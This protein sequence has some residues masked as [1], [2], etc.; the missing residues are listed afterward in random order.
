MQQWPRLSPLL[1]EGRDPLPRVKG[2]KPAS[3]DM[4]M[5]LVGMADSCRQLCRPARLAAIVAR[6]RCCVLSC[7]LQIIEL[8]PGPLWSSRSCI[9][10]SYGLDSD[11]LHGCD[12]AATMALCKWVKPRHR[13][14]LST[15]TAY[16]A[17]AYVAM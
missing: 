17:M 11:G 15:R 12:R 5:A 6:T 14:R 3:T 4:G 13:C 1:L 16:A 8:R 2:H 7:A 10:H 9:L